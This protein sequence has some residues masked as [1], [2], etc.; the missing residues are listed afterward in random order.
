[1]TFLLIK[2][3]FFCRWW[4][5]VRIRVL[6]N[7]SE[8]TKSALLMN[9]CECKHPIQ[10]ILVSIILDK[11]HSYRDIFFF[12]FATITFV[13]SRVIPL[14]PLL[15]SCKT[16]G[17]TAEDFGVDCWQLFLYLPCWGAARL[18]AARLRNWGLIAGS[19]SSISPAGELQDY[20]PD[21]WG[22]GVWFLAESRDFF[23]RHSA[24]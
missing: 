15:G 21:G 4:H 8:V 5:L 1:V 17:C 20:R 12:N 22:I 24:D 19:Y 10:K 3:L 13:S 11:F 18:R 16:T 6:C 23:L 7:T 14:Y 2:L 9:G